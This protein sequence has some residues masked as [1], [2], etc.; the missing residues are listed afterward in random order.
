MA[1]DR[2]STSPDWPPFLLFGGCWASSRF[3]EWLFSHA[4]PLRSI[5]SLKKPERKTKG[6]PEELGSSLRS[7]QL[8]II[9]Y[10][11][12]IKSFPAKVA[13]SSLNSAQ[14]PKFQQRSGIIDLELRTQAD[15]RKMQISARQVSRFE[16]IFPSRDAARQR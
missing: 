4:Y 9:I 10:V 2:P 5:C 3:S 12:C 6:V 11:H 16:N 7:P 15:R 13:V 14:Q 8:L 1:Q